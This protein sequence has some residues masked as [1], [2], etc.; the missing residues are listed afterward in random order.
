MSKKPVGLSWDLLIHPG[1]T[2]RDALEGHRMTPDELAA[3]TGAPL[4]Y[5][6]NVISGSADISPEFAAGL[7]TAFGVPAC[8]WMKLQENYNQEL[9]QLTRRNG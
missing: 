8:F 2:V 5:V 3:S 6:H 9:Q 4:E 7:E 1:E